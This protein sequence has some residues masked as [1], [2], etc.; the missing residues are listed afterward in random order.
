[1]GKGPTRRQ[2]RK[3]S[4]QS[5]RGDAG[6]AEIIATRGIGAWRPSSSVFADGRAKHDRPKHRARAKDAWKDE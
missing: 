1:M 4:R 2:G 3:T 6:R 5:E